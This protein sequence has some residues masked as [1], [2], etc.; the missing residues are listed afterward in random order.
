MI[1]LKSAVS[2]L[3]VRAASTAFAALLLLGL[4]LMAQR[5]GH[6]G[7]GG[8]SA[9]STGGGSHSGGS[10]SGGGRTAH[11]T[12]S[13]AGGRQPGR[14]GFRGGRGFSRG[15]HFYNYP[16]GFGFGFWPGFYWDG[17]YGDPYYYGYYGD[18]GSY[19]D[20][21]DAD[22]SGDYDRSDMGALDLDVSPGRTHVFVNGEDLG[23]VDR[24]DGWPGYLWLPEGTYDIAFY[25]PGY[26]TI[27]R[28]MTIYPGS[29]I[30]VDDRME[31]GESIRP[32]DLATKTHDRRDDRLRFERQ[33]QE[34]LDRQGG[35]DDDQDWRDRVRHD[36]M[37]KDDDQGG[38]SGDNH[39]DNN[40]GEDRDHGHA[41]RGDSA[42]SHLR[43][44]VEPR[45]ASVYLDGQF[46]GTGTDLSLLHAGLPVAPGSHKLAVVRPGRK[47]VE[48]TFDVKSGGDVE[49]E[50]A[51]ES[52]SGN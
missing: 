29:V 18:G 17:W 34:Q 9:H 8:G 49:L 7:G 38:D 32:E 13:H 16:F 26:K 3:P 39:G 20:R 10:H 27:A 43:L 33:R 44:A 46:V 51:L 40:R 42:Q 14:G 2:R 5:G 1:T 52:G 4:P 31:K 35:G 11:G 45:D 12:S 50:I 30:D 15:G 24:Y 36:R 41:M 6:S 21:G 37:M 23:I 25:L 19:Y 47:A 48:R 22:R 28:Q